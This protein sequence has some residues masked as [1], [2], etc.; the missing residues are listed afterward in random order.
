MAAKFIIGIDLGGTNLKIALLD[1]RF[2]ILDKKIL[3]TKS[4]SAREQLIRVIVQATESILAG[5]KLSRKQVVG[6]GV[7]LPG[8]IDAQKGFVHFFPN[9]PGWKN[10]NLRNILQKETGIPVAL[11]NDANLMALAEYRLGAARGAKNAICLTLGTGVGAGLILENKLFRGSGFA[12][13]ELGHLPVNISGPKCNCGGIACLEAYIGNNRIMQKVKKAFGRE[14]PLEELSRMANKGNIKALKIW[15]DVA[16]HLGR[17]LVAVV[18]L[19]N[20]ESIVIGGG[21]A[22]AGDLIFKGV[23]KIISTQAMPVHAAGVKILKAELG[24]DA[25]MIGAAIFAKEGR[26]V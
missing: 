21:V 3:S 18:N 7:G 25:G 24:S 13:G 1:L 19:L 11:D 4:Y 5:N 15:D 8:P 17:A 23:R 2:R 14:I 10:V 26:A 6:I 9:I 20:L 22:E 16:L 12:A